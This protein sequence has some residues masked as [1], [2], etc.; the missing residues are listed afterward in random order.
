MAEHFIE[1]LLT[2]EREHIPLDVAVELTQRCN[3]ACEHC[4]VPDH[5]V[6]DGLSTGRLLRLLEE[7]SEM[8]TLFLTFTGGEVFLR[9]DWLEIARH[10]RRLG[11]SLRLFSNGAAVDEEIARAVRALPAGVDISLYSLD[12]TVF[13]RITRCPGSLE[14]TLR[15]IETLR[16]HE[17]EVRLKVPIM[18]HNRDGVD[19]VFAY[20]R[21]LGVDCRPDPRIVH[22]KDGGLEPLE[23]Q[24]PNRELANYYRGPEAGLDSPEECVRQ[25]RH[26]GAL[27]AAGVRLAHIS[28]NGDVLACNLLPGSA[29][30]IN[31]RSFRDIW[32]HSPLLAELRGLRRS[33]L[34]ECADCARFAY[35]KRCMAQ[36][37]V[38]AGDLRSPVRWSCEHAEVLEDV[39]GTVE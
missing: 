3:Y 2:A 23:L 13:E 24:V 31:E 11:F 27:C 14:R 26:D 20:A 17:V 32:E 18:T 19:E 9:R 38:E 12:P 29:G 37:L 15:G 28:S 33:D 5:S 22:R 8:G 7:L 36:A 39:F 1:L 25:P 21:R 4:Y 16:A 30:N 6:P 10:A 34:P 35:C